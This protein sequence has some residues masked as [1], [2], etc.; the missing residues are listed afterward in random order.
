M[1]GGL[2]E[3]LRVNTCRYA[4][5][6]DD[7]AARRRINTD[8]EAATAIERLEAR[9]KE[10]EAT[11]SDLR[12]LVATYSKKANEE[13]S[14]ADAAERDLATLDSSH[15]DLA[16]RLAEMGRER[17]EA[18]ERAASETRAARQ[19]YLNAEATTPYGQGFQTACDQIA[20]AIRQL[21]EQ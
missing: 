13:R 19:N 6:S 16:Y 21:K 10:L 18:F 1:T 12:C 20:T 14:R 7:E 9:V 3:R 5:E 15:R 2:V 11:D 4:H 17:N 8:L